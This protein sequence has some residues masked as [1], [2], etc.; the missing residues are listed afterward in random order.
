MRFD[1]K[2]KYLMFFGTAFIIVL[3]DQM[4]KRFFT[5]LFRVGDSMALLPFLSFRLSYNTGAGFS[6]LQG[7]AWLLIWFSL[8]VIG[9]ILFVFDKIP[10]NCSLIYVALIFGGTIGNLIDRLAYGYVIDFIDFNF[11]PTF[12]LADSAICIGAVLL[13]FYVL[14]KKNSKKNG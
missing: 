4:L 11:W 9:I 1:I 3:I 6:L 10:Q 7:Q 12:N 5:G 14:R 8:M 13:G 2:N